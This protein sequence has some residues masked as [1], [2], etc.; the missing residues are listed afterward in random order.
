MN[1]QSITR[2]VGGAALAAATLLFLYVT[3]FDSFANGL[4]VVIAALFMAIACSVLGVLRQGAY[5]LWILT[6]VT[7][8]MY[9]PE[10][11]RQVGSFDL[12]QLIVPL[13]QA[14][15]F[16]MGTAMSVKD[17]AGV[18][19]TPQA[20]GIGLLCQLTIMPVIGFSLAY[21]FNFPPEIAAGVILVGCAPSG[22]A[23]NVMAYISK[24]NLA[25][26]VTLTAVAT[27]LSPFTTPFL[28]KAFAG[29]YIEI[30]AWAMMWTITKIVIL[31]IIAG[32]VFNHF[33]HGRAQWLDKAMPLVS[34][35]AIALIIVVI[36]AAGRDALLQIG[37]LLILAAFIHNVL[38]YMIG[39]GCARSLKMDEQ[40]C[41]SIAFE[42]GMQNTGL[43]SGI[44]SEMGR[45]ATLGL[46]PSVFGP[47][48]NI[49]GS[50]LASWWKGK[51]PQHQTE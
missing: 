25:L 17:F 45:V 39:Y 44:A 35:A 9:F 5:T 2:W 42:V 18:V 6:A 46:A 30:D 12:K 22:L 34:M 41:R 37:L 23:S 49:T 47:L 29:E 21:T 15:M 13:L 32:L 36:T 31:P 48:M 28:M 19:K 14:I 26:S 51:P 20:V 3:L 24:S 16:G 40:S 33:L 7:A 50:A 1:T 38:G 11:F 43:A 27:V 10:L 8:S 4:P